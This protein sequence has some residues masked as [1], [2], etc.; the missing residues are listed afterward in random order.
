MQDNV[1]LKDWKADMLSKF[2]KA[3]PELTENEI[4]EILDDDIAANFNDPMV[5]IHNDYN[6]D[7]KIDTPLSGIYR[8]NKEKKPILGGNGTLFYNQ[9]RISSPVADI[10]DDRIDTRKRYKNEMKQVMAKMEN[11]PKGTPQYDA[12]QEEYEYD[13]MM[14]AEAKIRINSIYGSFGAPSF[15]LYNKYT[16]AATTGTAQSLISATGISFESFIGN[17][18]KFKSL[19][20]CI[21]FMNNIIEEEYTLPK[22]NMVTF[23]ITKEMVLSRMRDNFFDGVYKDNFD[24]IIM[25]F[26]NNIDPFNLVKIY[27]KNNIFEWAQCPKITNILVGIFNKIDEFNNPNK[28]PKIITED[29]ELLWEYCNEYVFYNYA[30]TERINRLKNDEREVVKLIDT[31]SNLVHVQPWVTFLRE[32]IVPLSNSTMDSR[33]IDFA[34]VN[35]LAYLVTQMLKGLLEKYCYSANVLQRYHHRINMKNE[36]C[37]DPLLLAPSKKRYVGHQLLREGMRI[38]ETEIKGHDFR[39]SGVTEYVKK[40]MEKII[41]DRIVNPSPNVDIPGIVSDL[42]KIENEIETSLRNGERK[43]LM[44]MNCKQDIAYKNPLSMPQVLA[45]MAWNTIYPEQEIMLPDKLDVILTKIPD[46][47]TLDKIKDTF[48]YEYDRIRRLLLEGTVD[49]F[50]EKGVRYLAIPNNIDGIPDFIKPF[51]DFEYIKSRN[52]NT[53]SPITEALGNVNVGTKKNSHFSNIR[54]IS[55]IE[56]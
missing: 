36:F 18:V 42:V 17:H 26:L 1:F 25:R 40:S 50:R 43:F 6:D 2:K 33:S 45:V 16:A 19:D 44:R 22:D 4:L 29:I 53:F 11:V 47:K 54:K 56:I 13:D 34:C 55:K 20:E 12:L 35:I 27:Y 21:S 32:N 37:F 5:V 39:K 14:Q 46:V 28:V 30:Y 49:T 31:D 15:Q 52:L 48:P 3:Y 9:D 24:D 10:I 8:L 41:E 51:I 23:N 7:L 38:N